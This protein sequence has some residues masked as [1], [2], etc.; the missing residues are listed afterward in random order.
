LRLFL[1]LFSRRPLRFEFVIWDLSSGMR[2]RLGYWLSAI[3]HSRGALFAL[4]NAQYSTPFTNP[5]TAIA[6]PISHHKIDR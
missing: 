2:F 5:N 4:R 6:I 3:G 1:I